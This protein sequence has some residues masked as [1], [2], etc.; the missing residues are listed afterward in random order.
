MRIN[1]ITPGTKLNIHL[2]YRDMSFDTSSFVI[3]S[4]GD[5]A[6]IT[7]VYFTGKIIEY[8]SDATF[9]I[10]NP[11]TGIK[12]RFYIEDMSRV[13]FAGSD[14]HVIRGRE[15]T[16]SVD[17]RKA[18]RFKIQREATVT[19]KDKKSVRLIINDLSVRGI[20]LLVGRYSD[21]FNIGDEIEIDLV[22]EET[23]KHITFVSKI[24][25]KF[26]VGDLDA[27]GC[28]VKNVSTGLL[29]YLQFKKMQKHSHNDQRMF[30]EAI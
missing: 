30:E 11:I 1:S 19:I 17:N 16:L 4:Y 12:R 3:S 2:T 26:K 10:V 6:L 18:E 21:N 23:L 15:I 27:V 25:R 5:G 29:M 24:I 8:C 28:E 13:D 22:N 20:S 9:E 14:F 7:P